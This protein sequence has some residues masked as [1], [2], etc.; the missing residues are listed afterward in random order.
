MS[1]ILPPY[2]T[3][4]EKYGLIICSTHQS[5]LH[6]TKIL[7]HITKLHHD[8]AFYQSMLDPFR[9][10]TLETAHHMITSDQPIPPIPTL[11][12]P[13]PGFQCTRCG[14]VRLSQRRIR[15]HILHT[16]YIQGSKG[17]DQEITPCLV[18]ALEGSAYLFTVT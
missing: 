13:L 4:S 15:D 12:P 17:Q 16:Y 3:Y 14:L 18:Q 10:V 1:S 7:D 9:L 6:E 5:A 2:L 11:R 8:L